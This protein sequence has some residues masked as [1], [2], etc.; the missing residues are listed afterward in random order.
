MKL[1]VQHVLSDLMG[2]SGTRIVEAK[3]M[4]VREEPAAGPVARF[5][6]RDLFGLAF[7]GSLKWSA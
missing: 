3:H 2:G 7:G 5:H 6:A 1:H 4:L